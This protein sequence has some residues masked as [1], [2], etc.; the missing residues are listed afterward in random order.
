MPMGVRPMPPPAGPETPCPSPCALRTSAAH[1]VPVR[2]AARSSRARQSAILNLRGRKATR[3][4]RAPLA[5]DF[6]ERARVGD[7]VHRNAS[8]VVGG[9]VAHAV[10]A[11]LDAVQVSLASS[12]ITSAARPAGSS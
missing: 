9:D 1:V 12:S 6:A 8:Q 3:V 11:G 2:R 7:F 5:Q 10:A 4:Q